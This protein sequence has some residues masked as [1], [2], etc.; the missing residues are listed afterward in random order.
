MG[1]RGGRL[2][3]GR[4]RP[5]WL[6]AGWVQTVAALVLAAVTATLI[7]VS[8]SS[9]S[10]VAG[11]LAI[12]SVVVFAVATLLGSARVVGLT[13]VPVLGAALMASATT[14][15]PAWVRSM[16]LGCIWYVAVELAWDSIERR[17]GGHRSSALDHRRAF[18][19][20]TVVV[21]SLAVT[22]AGFAASTL[23]PQRTLFAQAAMVLVVLAALGFA[24][25]H[26]DATAGTVET[27][28]G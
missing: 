26:V 10:G 19:V 28:G 11:R 21:I 7:A 8:T 20:A 1:L 16:V 6:R 22:S 5:G 4:P 13:T 2:G 24:I 9:L 17:D 15:E 27:E 3:A 23:A 25:R 12:A 18:E 14:E